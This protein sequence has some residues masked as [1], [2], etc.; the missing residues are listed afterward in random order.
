MEYQHEKTLNYFDKQEEKTMTQETENQATLKPVAEDPYRMELGEKAEKF[1]EMAKNMKIENIDHYK[2]ADECNSSGA[3]Q[4][5][6]VEAFFNPHIKRAHETHKALTSDRAKVLNP[7]KEGCRLIGN[8]MVVFKRAEEE[9][10][11]KEQAARDKKARDDDAKARADLEESRL[12]EATDLEKEGRKEEAEDLINA[13]L[14]ERIQVAPAPVSAIPKTK[15]VFQD[16]WEYDVI[17]KSKV[18]EKYKIVDEATLNKL[19]QAS[20]GQLFMPGCKAVN[21]PIPKKNV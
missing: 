19:C 16:K 15:T 20:K 12:E 11:R 5:K 14:P 10:E 2:F 4:T 9:K 6:V 21:R 8:K 17:D 13:P 1:L 18:P 7:I 3:K